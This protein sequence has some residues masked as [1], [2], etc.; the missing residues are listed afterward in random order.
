MG[1]EQGAPP[2]THTWIHLARALTSIL[3][4]PLQI[5]FWH[6]KNILFWGRMPT[7]PKAKHHSLYSHHEVNKGAWPKFGPNTYDIVLT[8]VSIINCLRNEL[9]MIVKPLALILHKLSAHFFCYFREIYP[10]Y[11][12]VGW[13]FPVCNFF[14]PFTCALSR[15][16]RPTP[17]TFWPMQVRFVR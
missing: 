2:H 15:K 12:L 5:R 4:L 8:P 6:K 7:R 17:H 14:F 3:T 1:E 9:V 16:I 11:G 10:G 13:S